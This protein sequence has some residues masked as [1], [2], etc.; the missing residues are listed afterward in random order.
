MNT[1]TLRLALSSPILLLVGCLSTTTPLDL[2]VETPDGDRL[3]YRVAL[4]PGS[5]K[6]QRLGTDEEALVRLEELTKEGL[7]GADAFTHY[8]KDALESGVFN[9]VVVLDPPKEGE[10]ATDAYWHRAAVAA[11]ADLLIDIDEIRYDGRPQTEAIWS[12]YALFL[13]GPLE[14]V[15]PDRRYDFEE[16]DVSL[17]G[18]VDDGAP[19]GG[20]DGTS[21]AVSS[22][23]PFARQALLRELRVKPEPFSLRYGDRLHDGYGMGS[24]LKSF[25]VPTAHLSEENEAARVR[26]AQSLTASLARNVAQRIA[27]EDQAYIDRPSWRVVPFYLESVPTVTREGSSW[28][29]DLDL[30]HDESTQ[31]TNIV[32]TG[33]SSQPMLRPVVK[34]DKSNTR[35]ASA[36]GDEVAYWS[37]G[38]RPT[39]S[40]VDFSVNTSSVA[41]ATGPIEASARR[42]ASDAVGAVDGGEGW[43]QIAISGRVGDGDLQTRS[44]T[45][46]LGD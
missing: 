45:V 15:F 21:V 25:I 41:G 19:R 13:T 3:P 44:W 37:A 14:M 10:S 17:L 11:H 1:N 34:L 9:Q 18:P 40:T 38:E 43:V 35:E 6:Y 12:S 46:W 33:P 39:F 16:A 24:I 27:D 30:A 29:V 23:K 2:E 28:K 42:G 5:S 22:T 4:V 26:V 20:E 8:L 32:V 7:P 36:T 31:F